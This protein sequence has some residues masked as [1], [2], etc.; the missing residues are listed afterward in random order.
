MTDRLEREQRRLE[1][2]SIVGLAA[3]AAASLAEAGRLI[4][5]DRQ[6]FLEGGSVERILSVVWMVG[7]LLFGG[8][9]VA[10]WWRGRSQDDDARR[11]LGDEMQRFLSRKN[12]VSAFVMTYVAATI[13]AALPIAAELPGRA[14]ALI[15]VAVATASLATGRLA[16]SRS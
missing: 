9:F 2:W 8:M 4:G 16:V 13:L 12:A 5:L 7:L 10:L 15:V 1:T 14:V 11:V 3:L 6:W